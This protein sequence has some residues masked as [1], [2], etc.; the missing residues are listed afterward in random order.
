MIKERV[1][2]ALKHRGMKLPQ[3][4][5]QTGISRYTWSNLKNPAKT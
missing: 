1:I 5:Q 2:T 4:E 3:L